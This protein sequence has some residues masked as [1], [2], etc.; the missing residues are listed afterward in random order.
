MC[1][2][3]AISAY[4]LKIVEKDPFLRLQMNAK[5]MLLYIQIN[6]KCSSVFLFKN[7]SQPVSVL[8]SIQGSCEFLKPKFPYFPWPNFKFSLT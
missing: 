4:I 2:K 5:E 3:M 6:K 7:P 1:D 8:Y